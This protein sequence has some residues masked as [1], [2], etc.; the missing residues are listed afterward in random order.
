MS[1]YEHV[2]SPI[3]VRG[4]EFKNRIE[5]AP[6]ATKLATGEGL[7]TDELI[8]YYRTYARGGFAIVTVGDSVIDW[9]YAPGHDLSINLGSNRVITGLCDLAES[10]DR[11]GAQVSIEISH[12]GRNALPHLLG[13]RTPSGPSPLP[14]RME[15]M[16]AAREG[17]APRKVQEMTEEQ[18]E[19]V[20]AGFADACVRCQ[21]AGF[22]MVMLHGAHG[23]LLSQFLSPY[24]NRR[25][26][27][28]GGSLENRAR[29]PVAVLDAIRKRCPNLLLEYRI[30]LDE[31]VPGGMEPEEAI[32][33]LEMI[34]DKI[35]IVQVSAGLLLNPDTVQHMIQPLYVPHM[36]NLHLARL[37]KERVNGLLVT[38]V[39]SIM[40]LDNAETILSN[41]WADFVAVARPALA[42]PEMPRKYA[43]GR[44]EEVRPCVRC[45]C[46]TRVSTV[47]RNHRCAVNP[48]AGRYEFNQHEGLPRARTP[49]KLMIAGGGPAGMQAALTGVERG[50]EVV[51]YEMTGNLGGMLRTGCELPFKQDLKT[52]T[53]W[54]VDR[55]EQ[56]G[57]RIVKNTEVIADTVREENPDALI[58]A[59]GATP[60]VPSIPGIDSENVFWAGDVDTGKAV[61]G[62]R[63]IVVGAGMTGIETAIA[64]GATGRKVTVIEQMGPEVVLAEAPSAHRYYL[65]DRIREYAIEVVTNTCLKEIGKAGVRAVKK[66][67]GLATY[68]ADTIVLALG[69]KPRREKVAE[70][71]R[72][73]PATEV[74]VVGDCYKPGTLFTANHAGF[75][76]VCEL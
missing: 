10:V 19:H 50:H 36:Y 18:I 34:K 41:G 17:R 6:Q 14:N 23:H 56:C 73:V 28:W 45:N 75:N 9:D 76:A 29:L 66:D 15:E 21:T 44:K 8:H 71:R 30:S 24:S 65:L 59:V 20:I 54:L 55:A 40:D 52:Y 53:N 64:L 49:R 31:K 68:E 72:L 35:D 12:A 46:C 47:G 13:G 11:Y 2:F 26:D 1:D 48:M 39:G 67:L 38:T 4:V 63:V 22:N 5:V 32:K 7:V 61:P 57:A 74:F 37:V 58:I 51:L 25:N 69:M 43:T 70:L 42:D 16:M 27:R 62:D 33:F 3:T 60:I